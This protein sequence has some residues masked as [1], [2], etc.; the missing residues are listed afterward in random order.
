MSDEELKSKYD[1]LEGHLLELIYRY[2]DSHKK[3]V[4]ERPDEYK[5]DVHSFCI[6][7]H[8]AFEEFIEDVTLYSVNRIERE[9]NCPNRKFSFA[10][11]CLLHFDENAK[12]ITD[13]K[14]WPNVYNDYLSARI[15]KRKAELSRYAKQENHGI[16]I[17]YLR[18]LLLPIGIDVPRNP[19]E[20]SAL[21]KLKEIRGAYAHS[22]A[23][24]QRVVTPED[25]ENIVYDVLHMVERIK[26]KALN[27]SYYLI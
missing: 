22:Y 8:A 17:K 5:L 16:D 15:L 26:D 6:L 25:A 7:C 20:V 12:K 14:D 23:R 3:K 19:A 27:M 1:A 11:L 24:I 9:F 13:E 18:K 21:T 4:L 2:I 10:T